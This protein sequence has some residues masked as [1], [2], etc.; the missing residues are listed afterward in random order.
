MMRPA[1]R[2]ARQLRQ[3]ERVNDKGDGHEGQTLHTFP[4]EIFIDQI[5]GDEHQRPANHPYAQ[6]EGTECEELA[7]V[8]S[9]RIALVTK[10]P[11]SGR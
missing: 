8:N 2:K 10:K 7:A 6:G 1:E 9:A 4:P 11:A 5:G 3:D